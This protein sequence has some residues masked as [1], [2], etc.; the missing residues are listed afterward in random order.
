MA[1]LVVDTH[2]II[3]YLEGSTNISARATRA[4]DEA[5]TAGEPIYV[6]SITLVE[7]L[8]LVEKSLIA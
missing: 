6:A 4:I 5:Y 3:W 7:V 2:T 1:S 8:Y